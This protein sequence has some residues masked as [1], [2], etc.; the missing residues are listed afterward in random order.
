MENLGGEFGAAGTGFSQ[1]CSDGPIRRHLLL[2]APPTQPAD[3]CSPLSMNLDYPMLWCGLPPF[4]PGIVTYDP[5]ILLAHHPR[6]ARIV[7][8]LRQPVFQKPAPV[9][10]TN[11]HLSPIGRIVLIKSGFTS[12]PTCPCMHESRNLY[13]VVA[14]EIASSSSS[15]TEEQVFNSRHGPKLGQDTRRGNG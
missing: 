1:T 15:N 4:P 5:E 3:D 8:V 6:I 12:V 13:S 10:D 7:S 14:G 2:A 9:L 11:G